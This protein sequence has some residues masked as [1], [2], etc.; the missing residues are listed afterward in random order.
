LVAFTQRR[1]VAGA[2]SRRVAV[3]GVALVYAG[4]AT[5]LFWYG[6]QWLSYY[7]LLIGG[8]PGATAAGMEPTYYWDGLDRSVLDWLDQHTEG[9][10]KVH[11]AAPSTENLH[12][13]HVWGTLPVEFRSGAPGT[14][15]W[16]VLQRRPSAWQ[17]PDRWLIEHA[18]PAYRK[19]IRGGG[20]GPWRLDTVPLVEVYSYRD[21]LRA[22]EAAAARRRD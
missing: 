2:W 3:G 7:N 10:D 17:P 9:G 22:R 1:A 4:S 16:H 21:Y 8:L 19:V 6:P 11:F 12:L 13:M 15:R 18:E 5:S 14:Y 20:V